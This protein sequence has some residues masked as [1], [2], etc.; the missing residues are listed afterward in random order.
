VRTAW[1]GKGGFAAVY[2]VLEPA[3]GS[4]YALK[5]INKATLDHGSRRKLASEVELHTPLRHPCVPS[6]HAIGRAMRR[7]P[8]DRRR[9]A[10]VSHGRSIPA[11]PPPAPDAVSLFQPRGAPAQSI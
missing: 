4:Q 3:S 8:R 9:C 2:A 11:V 1:L 7:A 5:V 6:P 10:S